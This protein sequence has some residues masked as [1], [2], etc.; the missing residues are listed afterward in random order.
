VKH[1]P[2][3]DVSDGV[4]RGRARAALGRVVSHP[5]AIEV[6]VAD[7]HAILRGDV[8]TREAHD[9]I[10]CIARIPGIVEVT[11]GLARHTTGDVPALQGEGRRRATRRVW[12]PALQVGALG[13]GALLAL[14]GLAWRQGVRGSL[15]AAAGGALALRGAFNRPM[16]ELFRRSGV[17]VQKTIT[18]AAP[19]HRVFEL[20]SHPE[21]F[22]RFMNHVR[23][24][25]LDGETSRWRVDGPAGTVV[26]FASKVTKLEPDRLLS[27]RTLPDQPIEHEG[28]VRFSEDGE[29]TR[30]EVQLKYFPPGGRV[31]HTLAHL[32]GWDPKRRMDD[33]LMRMKGLLEEGLTH[34]HHARIAIE[35]LH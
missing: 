16:R 11:D 9:A 4:L 8:L 1:P 14:Y 19:I 6:D 7:G 31:A 25:E 24:V 2:A 5:A 33:D 15:L 32:L 23:S 17:V 30:V 27:W 28:T 13:G 34:A 29:R 26:A 12:P 21:N 22:P 20:W 10:R 35:D 18:V 3:R